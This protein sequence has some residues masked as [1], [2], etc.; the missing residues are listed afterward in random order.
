M[1]KFTAEFSFYT[2]ARRS[3]RRAIESKLD[4]IMFFSHSPDE[5]IGENLVSFILERSR[6]AGA[7]KFRLIC[8]EVT[9]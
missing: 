8:E 6:G 4:G 1:S 9:E 5:I 3:P 7:H 2:D